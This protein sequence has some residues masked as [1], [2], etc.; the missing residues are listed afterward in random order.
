MLGIKTQETQYDFLYLKLGIS[1]YPFYE[2]I[3][4]ALI[5]PIRFGYYYD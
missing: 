5:V 1:N 4:Y 2:T 3:N